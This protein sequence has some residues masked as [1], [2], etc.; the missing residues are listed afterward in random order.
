[1]HTPTVAGRQ[2]FKIVYWNGNNFKHIKFDAESSTAEEI[3]FK[4][5]N[6]MKLRTSIRR[7]EYHTIKNR[8]K[9]ISTKI[10]FKSRLS[11]GSSESGSEDIVNDSMMDTMHNCDDNKNHHH[12]LF[13][14][15][16]FRSKFRGSKNTD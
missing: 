5:Q 9:N 4:L 7:N 16:K 13:R 15:S 6:V 3:V 2:A 14:T 8:K 1:M 12:D 10:Y 11:S